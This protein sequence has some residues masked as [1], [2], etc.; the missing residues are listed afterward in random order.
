MVVKSVKTGYQGFSER[1][2]QLLDQA[3][4][5]PLEYGRA[6]HLG[7]KFS[8]SKSG[9]RKWIREDTPPRPDKLRV[10]IEELYEMTGLNSLRNTAKVIAWLQYGEELGAALETESQ[11]VFAADHILLSNVY[12]AVHNAAKVKHMDLESLP[13]AKLDRLYGAVIKQTIESNSSE[14]DSHLIKTL[15]ELAKG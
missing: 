14:P 7:D 2:N 9:A 13:Q 11:G 15:L 12:L 3:G 5:P 10:I 1:F 6:R 8:V 4:Y